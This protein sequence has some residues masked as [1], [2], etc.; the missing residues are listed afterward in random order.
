MARPA[1]LPFYDRGNNRSKTL[2]HQVRSWL[3]P[4]FLLLF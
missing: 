2:K 3:H 4:F 1:Q